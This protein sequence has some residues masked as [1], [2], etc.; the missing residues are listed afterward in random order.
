M[1]HEILIGLGAILIVGMTAQWLAWRFHFPSILILLTFGFIVGPVTGFLNPDDIFGRMLFPFVSLSVAI[2]LFEGG[3]SLRFSEL[4]HVGTAI[5]NLVTFGA[6]ITWALGTIFAV[7]LLD[8]NFKLAALLGAILVVTGP[9]V[10]GPLLRQLRPSGNVASVLKWE[11]IVIDP[12]G[13]MLSVL[14]LEA[15]LAGGVQAAIA[16]TFIGVLKTVFVGTLIG[17]L[18]AFFLIVT[19]KRYWLPDFLQSPISLMMVVLVYIIPNLL[20][21]ESGLF[22]ATIMGIV[23]ANQ[24]SVSIKKI[25]EFKENLR[26]LLI[27][28]LFIILAAR[29]RPEN[30]AEINAGVFIFIVIL[31]LVVRPAAVF[32]STIKSKL[33]IKEKIFI[34]WMAPRGIVAAAVA[35]VFSFELMS[36]GFED[37]DRLVTITFAVIVGTVLTYSLTTPYLGRFLGLITPNPQGVLIVGAHFWARMI[38][39][40]LKEEDIHVALI[41]TNYSNISTARMDGLTA[42]EKNVLSATEADEVDL[43]GVGKIFALTPNDEVNS[44]AAIRFTS[45]FGEAQTYQLTPAQAKKTEKN[46]Q[47]SSDYIRGRYLF[48]EAATCSH[49]AASFRQGAT[50][51]KTNLTEE[52]TFE[53]FVSRY[54]KRP[55][56]LFLITAQ[57]ELQVFNTDKKI[58][59]KPGCTLISMIYPD[60]ELSETKVP[61]A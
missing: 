5:R 60:S 41:D 18:G 26:V 6:L 16:S 47:D 9:T 20:V 61:E 49:L 39:K 2:I 43:Q 30:I 51:K 57:K 31:I 45:V 59:P 10:V 42:F 4:P 46:K 38:G 3:L 56:P 21:P 24:K 32:L 52:F 13:A 11:G 48:E 1:S 53:K 17:G 7:I 15:V 33:S 37:A 28:G 36:R 40:A 58:I 55:I 8:L 50:I 25:V 12:I 29:L 34:S 23:I 14:V 27:S 22:S 44:L 54:K 35:S 19:L